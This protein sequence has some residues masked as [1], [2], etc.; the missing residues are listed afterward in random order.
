M[1]LSWEADQFD[2]V[3]TNGKVSLE[4]P[5]MKIIEPGNSATSYMVWKIIGQGPAGEAIVGVRMPASG[6]PF[7]PQ[8]DIDRITAWID[9]GAPGTS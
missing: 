7:L 4:L 2:A 3:V 1:G 6:P 9:A 5:P 8:S